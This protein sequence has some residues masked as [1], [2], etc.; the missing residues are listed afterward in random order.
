[1]KKGIVVCILMLMGIVAMGCSE[2]EVKVEDSEIVAEVISTEE[3]I[4]T[5]AMEEANEDT[6]YTVEEFAK[7]MGITYETHDVDGLY[8]YYKE[9][10]Q[11]KTYSETYRLCSSKKHS[12]TKDYIAWMA[13]GEIQEEIGLTE[14]H[15][16]LYE[17]YAYYRELTEEQGISKEEANEKIKTRKWSFL[18]EDKVDEVGDYLTVMAQIYQQKGYSTDEITEMIN[19]RD[20]FTDIVAAVDSYKKP[21]SNK[22]NFGSGSSSVGGSY[23]PGYWEEPVRTPEEAAA[24]RDKNNIEHGGVSIE[25]LENGTPISDEEWEK[26]K[27]LLKGL[28]GY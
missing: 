19:H 11:K 23:P 16:D 10:I 9:M 22:G 8:E 20:R 5:E 25:E 6:L 2:S 13:V 26:E 7:I 18:Y 17:L 3:V 12:Y 15:F 14:E 4:A 1:M 21:S 28:R 24:A 27:E